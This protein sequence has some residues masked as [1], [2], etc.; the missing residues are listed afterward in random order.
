MATLLHHLLCVTL[1]TEVALGRV[2]IAVGSSD[3]GLSEGACLLT[4]HDLWL[5]CVVWV[6]GWGG[7]CSH[8]WLWVEFGGNGSLLVHILAWSVLL[9]RGRW[10]YSLTTSHKV[11]SRQ[12]SIVL[13]GEELLL[14]NCGLWL[15]CYDR[16]DCWRGCVLRWAS[17]LSGMCHLYLHL[18]L[19][20][21]ML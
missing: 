18:Y 11:F 7:I 19:L 10:Y 4:G 1:E 13:T 3:T 6:G 15:L 9:V 8:A 17:A 2:G 21:L 20:S 14:V 5:W 16:L 12:S